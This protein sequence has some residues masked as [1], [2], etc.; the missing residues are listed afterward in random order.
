MRHMTYDKNGRGY[1]V[2]DPL[3]NLQCCYG[4]SYVRAIEALENGIGNHAWEQEHKEPLVTVATEREQA[5]EDLLMEALPFVQNDLD[6][7]HYDA[8]VV[9][10]IER[11]IKTVLKL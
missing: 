3:A 4:T 10:A 8:G 2:K 6:C 7:P 5:I 1:I 9:E 11:K